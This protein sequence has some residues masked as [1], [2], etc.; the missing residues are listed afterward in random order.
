M[1]KAVFFSHLRQRN[2]GVF[3]T[4]LSQAQVEGT[5]AVLNECIAQRADTAQAAYILATAYGETGGK[6]QPQRS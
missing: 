3:G 4:S 5:E 1:D 6:M 2:S